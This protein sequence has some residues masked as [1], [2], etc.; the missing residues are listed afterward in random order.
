MNAKQSNLRLFFY[1]MAA[2]GTPIAS[3]YAAMRNAD[4]YEWGG[5]IIQAAV[6]AFIAG[7]AYIDTSESQVPKP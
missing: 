5:M 7:R 6:A 4:A 3:N 2:F 1:M